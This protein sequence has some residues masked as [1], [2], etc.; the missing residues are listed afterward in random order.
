[1]LS[2]EFKLYLKTSIFGLSVFALIYFY[3]TWMQIPGV[4]NKSVADTA[5]V[6]M[7]LSMLISGLS[8]FWKSL[9]SFIIYRKY[10]GLIGFAFATVHLILSWSALSQ[11]LQIE[12][13]Q[14]L[15]IGAPLSGLLAFIIFTMMWMISNRLSARLLGGNLWRMLLRTGYLALA[16]VF[17]HIYLLKASRWITWYQEGMTSPPS[18]SLLSAIFIIVVIVMRLVMAKSLR[19]K[20]IR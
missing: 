12:L 9:A 2:P 5:V 17:I 11:L 4:L 20:K 10:L 18:A 16:L 3:I 8:Y 7:G 14:Q 1:M 13:W 19:K 15:K 6:L